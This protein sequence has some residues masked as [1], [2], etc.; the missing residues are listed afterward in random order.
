MNTTLRNDMILSTLRVSSRGFTLCFSAPKGIP[1]ESV[2]FDYKPM[3]ISVSSE[4]DLLQMYKSQT[5]G[6]ELTR[7]LSREREW[8]VR[9]RVD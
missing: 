3:I 9:S 8:I 4:F 7:T 2:L 5:W 1:I 6:S